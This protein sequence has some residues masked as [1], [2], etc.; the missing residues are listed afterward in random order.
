MTALRSH[1]G[2][3]CGRVCISSFGMSKDPDATLKQLLTD[4][5][6]GAT[7]TRGIITEVVLTTKQL[8]NKPALRKAL[9]KHGFKLVFKGMNKNSGNML[10]VFMHHPRPARID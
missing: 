8:R 1:G 10:H 7:P 5:Y 2:G 3:C 6:Q 9:D 4:A